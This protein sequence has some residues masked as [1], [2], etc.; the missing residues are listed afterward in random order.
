MK[1]NVPPNSQ[2]KRKLLFETNIP[3]ERIISCGELYLG[4]GR[5]NEAAEMFTRA[6]H[7]EG[8]AQLRALAL[9][10]GDSFLYGVASKGSEEA[11]DRE[12]WET[13]GKKAMELEKY[14]H[15]I[16]AFRKAENEEALEAAAEALKEEV[17][18]D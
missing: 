8:L 4:E 7:E 12:A 1:K 13:L 16:R 14:S 3:S 2:R 17:S 9:E 10:Q 5:L 15:A 6:S 18:V 11:D